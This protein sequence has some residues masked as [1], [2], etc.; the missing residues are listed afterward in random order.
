MPA[1]PP[2][3]YNITV[4]ANGFKTVHQTGIVLEADQ[5]ARIDFALTIGSTTETI[6]VRRRARRC[7]TPQTQ[8]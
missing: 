2:G 1:L 5:Q 6:T 7:S 8:P 4:E 3:P